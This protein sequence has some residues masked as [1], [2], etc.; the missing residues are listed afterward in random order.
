MYSY[1]PNMPFMVPFFRCRSRTA[2]FKKG[3]KWK[4]FA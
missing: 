2:C 4:V 3:F 1:M